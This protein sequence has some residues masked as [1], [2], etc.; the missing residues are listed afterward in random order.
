MNECKYFVGGELNVFS[1]KMK[2]YQVLKA[3]LV[4]QNLIVGQAQ[5]V[6]SDSLLW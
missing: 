1:S 3:N 6:A 4:R 2:L 5:D